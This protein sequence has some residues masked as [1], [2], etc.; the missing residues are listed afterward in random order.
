VW[1]F[2]VKKKIKL[3]LLTGIFSMF[4]AI[5]AS[6]LANYTLAVLFG[7]AAIRNYVFCYLDWRVSKGKKVSKWLQ[8]SFAV[9]FAVATITA[10]SMLW[11]FGMALWLEVFICLTLLGLIVGN[12]LP[13]TNLM[14]VSFIANRA[15]NIVNHVYF[16][17]IIAVVIAVCAIGSNVIYYIRQLV[18]WLK[19]RNNLKQQQT[20]DI[21]K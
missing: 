20:V 21:S 2:Q 10:T 8:Y 4:L 15:F 18:I 9:V 19:K 3:L 13:G 7:L 17:N 14:R 6:F 5:S 1:A 16:N 12:I 11:H